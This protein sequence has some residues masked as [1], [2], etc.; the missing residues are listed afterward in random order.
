MCRF[1]RNVR[2]LQMVIQELS[3]RYLFVSGERSREIGGLGVGERLPCLCTTF[4]VTFEILLC[5]S[6]LLTSLVAQ[7]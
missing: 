6:I 3:N 5:V 7:W 1:V 4:G 2:D